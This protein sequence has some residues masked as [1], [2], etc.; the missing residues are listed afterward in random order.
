MIRKSK[1]FLTSIIILFVASSFIGCGK[2]KDTVKEADK[3]SKATEA[4]L[5][6]TTTPITLKYWVPLDPQ[7]SAIMKSLNDN[8]M[9]KELEKRTG[10]KIEFIHPSTGNVNDQYNLMIASNDL[11]DIIE[12]TSTAYQGGM[13]KAVDDKVFVKLNDYIDKYAPNYKKYLEQSP[14]LKKQ[15]TTNSGNIVAFYCIEPKSIVGEEPAWWGPQI[16]KDWLDGLGMQVPVTIND[17]YKALKGFKE[18]YGA[19]VPLI[20]N[21]WNADKLDNYDAFNGAFGV[22]REWYQADGKVKYGPIE[23]K[24]KDFL[25][26]MNKWYVEG[27]LDKDFP[28]RDSKSKDALITSGKTGA[29]TGTSGLNYTNTVQGMKLVAT[30]YPV[31]NEGDKVHL[32]QTNRESKEYPTSITTS[33]KHVKEAVRWMDYAYSDDGFKLFNYGIEGKTYTMVDNKP[34]LNDFMLNNPDGIKYSNLAWKY[35]LHMGPYLRD[36]NAGTSSEEG[37]KFLQTWTSTPD[38]YVLPAIQLT[39]DENKQSAEIMTALTSYKDEMVL[40]FIIGVEP[41]SKFDDYVAQIK[42]LGIDKA[43]KFRQDALDRYNSK[44]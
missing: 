26:T 8:E 33:C 32:R 38:D 12:T 34:K 1:R 18:K 28:T 14:D 21:S 29:W 7:A 11:P 10:I 13:D 19:D 35:K 23:P 2:T 9:Y 36:W 4:G 16:R 42:K 40:K 17:W 37:N 41:L 39:N 43:I 30:Q 22:S 3:D 6:I 27:L 25:T 31:L 24:F 15:V 44:K 5:P 20:I